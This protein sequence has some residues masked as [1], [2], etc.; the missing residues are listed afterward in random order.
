MSLKRAASSEGGNDSKYP[1]TGSKPLDSWLSI[2]LPKPPTIWARSDPLNDE[3]S[4]FLAWAAAAESPQ[5]IARLRNY[6]LEVGNPDFRPDPPSH[7]AHGARILS[8]KPGRSGLKEEDFEVK[9]FREDDGENRA[10]MTI[11]D[12]LSHGAVDVVVVVSRW[13]GGTMLGPRRFNDISKVTLEAL[14]RFRDAEELAKVK[15]SLSSRDGDIATL[16]TKLNRLEGK[17]VRGSSPETFD[18]DGLELGKAKRLLVARDMRVKNLE[19]R[20]AKLEQQEKEELPDL[21]TRDN[22]RM[23]KEFDTSQAESNKAGD[24]V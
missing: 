4:T 24:P 17:L 19:S 13:F 8:L 12:T 7:T 16:L 10:G 11:V 14:Y 20:I 2:S 23:L 6:V 3:D 9:T 15:A 18:Y 1:R 21:P 5:D 22:W